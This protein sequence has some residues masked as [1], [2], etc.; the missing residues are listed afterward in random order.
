ML[1]HQIQA[2]RADEAAFGLHFGVELTQNLHAGKDDTEMLKDGGS[3]LISD[4]QLES[5][6]Q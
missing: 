2:E 4:V 3:L 5:V 6:Y 1:Q